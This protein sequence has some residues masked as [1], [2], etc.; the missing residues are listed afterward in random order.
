MKKFF[1]RRWRPG[2]TVPRCL[3]TIPAKFLALASGTTAASGRKQ[4]ERGRQTD[5]LKTAAI[6][7]VLMVQII[8]SGSGKLIPDQRRGVH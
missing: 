4:T 6:F 2:Q 8:G 5:D 1:R 7:F 3:P